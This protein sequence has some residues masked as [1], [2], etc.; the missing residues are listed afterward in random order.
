MLVG[1]DHLPFPN[2]NVKPL[3]Q[4]TLTI[5]LERNAPV[6]SVKMGDATVLVFPF[7]SA[8]CLLSPL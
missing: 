2:A 1:F 3:P 7:P 5:N 8:P 6:V 4:L